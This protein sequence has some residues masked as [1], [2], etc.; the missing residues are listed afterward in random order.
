MVPVSISEQEESSKPSSSTV[1]AITSG[2]INGHAYVDLG[3][4]VKWATMNVGASTPGDYGDYFAWGEVH[5]K[6]EYTEKN[7]QTRKNNISNIS[8]NSSS[9]AACYHWGSSWRLPTEKELEE[10][11]D[12]CRWSW[13]QQDG[14]SGYKV[15]GL[16]GNSIFLPAAGLRYGASAFNVVRAGYYWSGSPYERST[17]YAFCLDFDVDYRRVDWDNRTMV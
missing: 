15:V 9:D 7:S 5:P 1:S 2:T 11:K 16:N 12:K 17:K 13:T 14:H 3:L 6:S 8:G 10:L 4:S